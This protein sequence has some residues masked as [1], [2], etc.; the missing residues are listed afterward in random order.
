[1]HKACS[2]RGAGRIAAVF[3]LHGTAQSG[4]VGILRRL[5]EQGIEVA[6]YTALFNLYNLYANT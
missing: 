2:R 6:G 4:V 1:M 3:F 5:C